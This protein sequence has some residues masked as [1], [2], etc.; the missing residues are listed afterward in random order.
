MPQVP[1]PIFVFAALP[2]KTAR[3]RRYDSY[4]TPA[5]HLP[6]R[7]VMR[8]GMLREIRHMNLWGSCRCT[9]FSF[10]RGAHARISQSNWTP[11]AGDSSIKQQ[12]NAAGG[13]TP[14]VLRLPCVWA[15]G[16]PPESSATRT[17]IT[18]I[19]GPWEVEVSWG[20]LEALR[21]LSL[22]QMVNSPQMDM[23]I[24]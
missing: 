6:P 19:S 7:K 15:P 14:R 9:Y 4:A 11:Y 1:C 8:L 24:E 21:A 18:N 22:R 16:L 20:L 13:L 23:I 10:E 3:N 2:N 17:A 5:F 12:C